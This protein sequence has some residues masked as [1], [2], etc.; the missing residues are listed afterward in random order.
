M[1]AD[2][3]SNRNQRIEGLRCEL[4]HRVVPERMTSVHHLRPRSHGG[5]PENEAVLCKMCHSFLH[6]TFTNRTLAESFDSVEALR[7]D[8]EV[9][10]F[11]KWVRKQK[12]HRSINVDRRS[13]K[14]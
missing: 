11:L 8:P 10:K 14:R 12:P 1:N 5:G 7:E 13:E 2:T 6:A 4:C 3:N 9:R